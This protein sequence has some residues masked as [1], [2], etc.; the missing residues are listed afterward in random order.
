MPNKLCEIYTSESHSFAKG[1]SRP[2]LNPTYS[3]SL[4]GS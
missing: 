4:I 3:N 1:Y 2:H